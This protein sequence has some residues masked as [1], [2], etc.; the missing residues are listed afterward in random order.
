MGCEGMILE[1]G[2]DG[3]EQALRDNLLRV[4]NFREM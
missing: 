2:L 3:D 1:V 4:V